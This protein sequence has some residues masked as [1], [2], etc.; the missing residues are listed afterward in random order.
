MTPS[1]TSVVF[2]IESDSN[3]NTR[4]KP[5]ILKLTRRLFRYFRGCIIKIL[6]KFKYFKKRKPEREQWKNLDAP[7]S[8]TLVLRSKALVETANPLYIFRHII[9]L[10]YNVADFVV[11]SWRAYAPSSLKHIRSLEKPRISES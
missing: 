10:L 8:L 6:T 11:Y 1:F 3:S 9:R 4:N 7:R 2:T 5:T